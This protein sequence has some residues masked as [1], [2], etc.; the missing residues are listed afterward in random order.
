[1]SLDS[2]TS[3]EELSLEDIIIS[4]NP[5]ADVFT[6]SSADGFIMN[7]N[8]ALTNLQGQQVMAADIRNEKQFA[9][10]LKNFANGVYLLK[11]HLGERIVIRKLV[12]M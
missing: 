5:S 10:D 3:I 9:I 2:S 7:G 11:M 6:I 8:F 4:P 12:K 1:M